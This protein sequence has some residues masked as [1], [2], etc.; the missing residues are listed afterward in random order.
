MIKNILKQ[1]LIF[2]LV[3]PLI[4]SCD[5]LFGDEEDDEPEV[6]VNSY[7]II[8]SSSDS[9]TN[10]W[11]GC[12]EIDQREV[13]ISLWDHGQIDGDIVSFY[14]NGKEVVSNLT[15]DGPSN[16]YTFTRTLEYN[17]FNYVRLK[18]HNLGDISPNTAT[19]SIDG[20]EFV[21]ESDLSNNGCFD[22]V[23]PGYGVSCSDSGSGSGSGSGTGT[24]GTGTG[25]GTGTGTGSGSTTQ[26]GEVSFYTTKDHGCGNITVQISGQGSKTLTQYFYSDINEC[27]VDGAVTW[28]LTP[29]S[30][31]YSA[32]CDGYTW[33][34][35]TITI[36]GNGCLKYKLS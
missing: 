30:Y 33:G 16:K 8:P 5:G 29:G 11:Q 21:L 13:T 15:L 23:V 10:V 19:V 26:Y 20:T 4:Y 31:T 36:T 27:A 22:I 32:S 9:R 1:L 3:A 2:L 12:V 34:P 17:G 6:E 28:S 18:A 14:V 25:S 7:S 35:A 24:T